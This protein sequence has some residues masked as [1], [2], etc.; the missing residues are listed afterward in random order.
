MFFRQYYTFKKV[1]VNGGY[2]CLI[3]LKYPQFIGI[4]KYERRKTLKKL[5]TS[6]HLKAGRKDIVLYFECLKR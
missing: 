5:V 2:C 6:V 1:V 3:S 4:S